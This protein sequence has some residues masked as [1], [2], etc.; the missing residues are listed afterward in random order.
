MIPKG[1]PR[2]DNAYKLIA[3]AGSPQAQANLT[4]YI[5]YAPG[6]KEAVALI[7]PAILLN[8]PTAP[9][10]MARAQPMN[11]AFWAEKGD[12]LNQRFTA[13]LAK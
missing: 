4:Q 5:P 8:V 6:N 12:E 2:L 9:D 10:H 11:N 1:T 3:F 13:W 7:D